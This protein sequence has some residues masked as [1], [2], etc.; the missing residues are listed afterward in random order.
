ME[1]TTASILLH[2]RILMKT[3]AKKMLAQTGNLGPLSGTKDTSGIFMDYIFQRIEFQGLPDD[4]GM[5]W[6]Y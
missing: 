1:F 2:R 6:R 3:M 4:H 5:G